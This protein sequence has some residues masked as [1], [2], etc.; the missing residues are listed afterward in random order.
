[1]K[2]ITLALVLTAVMAHA[3][4]TRTTCY[5]SGS[6]E[7]CE[8][9]DNMGNPISKTR[10]Y[11]SGKDTRCDTQSFSGTPTTPFILAGSVLLACLLDWGC[12]RLL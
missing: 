7:I 4:Q 10:C 11:R 6:T 8:T 3:Q 12:G 1:M 9:F 2:L 5:R